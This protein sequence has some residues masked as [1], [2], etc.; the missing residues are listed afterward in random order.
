ML[1]IEFRK[2]RRL[3]LWGIL[4]AVVGILTVWQLYDDLDA[5]AKALACGYQNTFFQL[6]TLNALFLPLMLAV[7]AS[8]LCDVEWK[9]DTFKLLYTL[10]NKARFYDCKFIHSAFYLLLFTILE[11]MMVPF[12]GAVCGYTDP[13]KPLK[14]I[15]LAGAILL[16]GLLILTLQHYLSL[17]FA[18]QVIPLFVGLSGSFLGLFANFLP[19]QVVRFI[20]W[21][22]FAAF[23]TEQMHWDRDTREMWFTDI[24]FPAKKYVLLLIFTVLFYIALRQLFSSQSNERT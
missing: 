18:N 3:Y 14:L 15:Q 22:Y 13:F 17:T 24:P 20:P 16:P 4:L 7:F 23:L 1:F 10:Q 9:G 19:P 5:D 21:S 8:R 12:L 11:C 2:G 6:P